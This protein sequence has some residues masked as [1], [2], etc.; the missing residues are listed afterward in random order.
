MRIAIA[1]TGRLGASLLRPLLRSEHEVVAVLQ[2]GRKYPAWQ[3]PAVTA[4]SPLLG[5][6]HNIV[7][8]AKRHRIPILWLNRLTDEA[9]APLRA[10]APDLIL[11]GGFGIIFKAPLLRLPRLGCVNCHSSLLPRHRGPNPFSAVILQ[12]ETQTGVTFHAMTEG[13]DDGDILDQHAF[14]LSPEDTVLSIYHQACEV[15]GERVLGVVNRVAAE[16]VRGVPQDPACATYDKKVEEDGAWIDWS[17]P[18]RDIERMV[19]A[20]APSPMPR[21]AWNGH[22]IRVAK[23]EFDD[24]PVDQAPGTIV[25]NHPLVRVATGLGTVRLRVAFVSKPVPWIWPAPWNRP[26]VG[27]RLDP[28]P[29]GTSCPRLGAMQTPRLAE[30]GDE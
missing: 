14:A 17:L 16:G 9:L 2:D 27:V 5:R 6:S 25:A 30:P 15:A 22:V 10:L 29:P 7:A 26:D 18:A 11:V 1:G 12:G 3:R 13:I 19:R 4:F 23:V 28:P 20:L 8:L 24:K 21:L